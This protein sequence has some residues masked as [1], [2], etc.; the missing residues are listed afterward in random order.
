[1][2]QPVPSQRSASAPGP[3]DPTAVQ[4]RSP[5]HETA[6]SWPPDGLA[7]IDQL[8]PFQSSISPPL[9]TAKQT[10]GR[11]QETPLSELLP[12]GFGVG[13]I[14]QL[15]PFQRSASV[16]DACPRCSPAL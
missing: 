8:V 10:F 6:L 9:P 15:V 11:G 14:C 12:G 7:W 2:C 1:M 13:T 5:E 16:V 3:S 4:A